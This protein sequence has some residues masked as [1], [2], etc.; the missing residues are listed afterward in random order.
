VPE[1]RH[2]ALGNLA[3]LGLLERRAQMPDPRPHRERVGA[4][5][6]RLERIPS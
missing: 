2:A 6:A 5:R 3:T 4:L 1:L